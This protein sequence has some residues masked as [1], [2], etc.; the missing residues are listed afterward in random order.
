MRFLFLVLGLVFQSFTFGLALP[1]SVFLPGVRHEYQR[2]NN[3]G[4]TT[5]GMAMS[6]YGNPDTQYQIAPVLKP[7]KQDKNVSSDE[8]MAFARSRGYQVQLGIAGNLNLLKQLLANNFPVIIETW[9]VTPDHGGMG[10]YRLLVGYSD[11]NQ[12]FNA[13]DSYYGPKVTLRYGE[14]DGLWQVFNRTYLVVYPSKRKAE[15]EAILGNRL[16]PSQQ[17][18]TAL[19]LAQH[20][21]QT[22]PANAFAWFNLGT[23]RLQTGDPKGAVEAYD[24]SQRLSP[25]RKFDPLRPAN[26]V[27]NWPWRTMWYQ[28]G[29]YQAYFEAGRYQEVLALSNDVLRRVPDHEESYYWRGRVRQA[30]GNLKAAKADFQAALYYRPSYKAAA[31]ALQALGVKVSR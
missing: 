14:L 27:N 1:D 24:Q 22:N 7:N 13:F 18:Q 30:Q 19:E 16:D 6:Y 23:M 10:H 29:P 26:A 15:L 2:F 8:M 31:E 4:P 9:F 3:C 25:S 12:W 5:L 28:F 21:T 17:N 20:E 11:K